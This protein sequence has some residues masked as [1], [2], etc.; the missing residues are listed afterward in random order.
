MCPAVVDEVLFPEV[1]SSELALFA[2]YE[3]F[4]FPVVLGISLGTPWA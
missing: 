2:Y 3:L 1:Q 4:L